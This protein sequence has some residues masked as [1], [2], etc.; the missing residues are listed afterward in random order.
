MNKKSINKI[1]NP[2]GPYKLEL[3]YKGF[4]FKVIIDNETF[5]DFEIT[6]LSKLPVT[7]NLLDSL[8]EYLKDEGFLDE[9]TQH[10]LYW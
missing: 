8:K 1:K 9:A 10:N 3:K 6:T 7:E 4:D 2:K 5:H